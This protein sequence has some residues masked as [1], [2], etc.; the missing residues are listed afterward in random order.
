MAKKISNILTSLAVFLIPFYFFRFE[1]FGIPTN[2]FEIAVLI[3]FIFTCCHHE[4]TKSSRATPQMLKGS[5]CRREPRDQYLVSGSQNT[6]SKGQKW[7]LP[8][9]LLILA[10][11]SVFISPEKEKALGIFKGWFLVPIVFAWLIN[12]NF[13]KENIQKLIL[14]LYISTILISAWALLQKIGIISTLLYQVG[15]RSFEQYVNNGRVFGPFESPNYLAMFL[16]PATLIS[17]SILFE[18]AYRR[19]ENFLAGS[20]K[21]SVLVAASYSLPLLAI[22]FSGSR[23]GMISLAFGVLIF[24]IL[25]R[26]NIKNESKPVFTLII[27]GS[28]V[29]INLLY[30]CFTIYL[31]KNPSLGDSIRIEIYKYSVTLLK[32]Y[33]ILGVGLS[34]FQNEIAKLSFASHSFQIS[35]LSYA[36]HPHNLVLAF[37]LNLGLAG[38]ILFLW[39]VLDIF[40][41]LFFSVSKIKVYFITALCV[42]LIHGLFDTTYFKNDLSAIFWLIFA[43]SLILQ[44]NET[45]NI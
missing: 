37:W 7:L 44:Q 45:K 3:T 8:T 27:M 1:I 21:I 6:W 28:I 5:F 43:S 33:P 22:F 42:I 31:Y 30:L 34:N 20:K 10:L 18:S 26:R 17:L 15:D 36:L 12:R 14:P 16:A 24:L 13:S 9:S 11:I 41:R 2:V 25:R 35:G 40:K 23:A 38:L 29:L 32:S 19:T 4:P 39:L